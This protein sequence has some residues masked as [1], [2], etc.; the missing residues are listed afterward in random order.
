MS[1]FDNISKTY[2]HSIE[3]SDSDEMTSE[4]TQ[5]NFL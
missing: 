1:S 4:K 3:H 5:P 2:N